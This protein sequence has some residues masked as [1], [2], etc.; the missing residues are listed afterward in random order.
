MKS[1]SK[2]EHGEE[3][4]NILAREWARKLNHYFVLWQESD[5]DHVLDYTVLPDFVHTS[6]FLDWGV[7][8]DPASPTWPRVNELHA[9]LPWGA[10]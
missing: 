4:G 2:E 6:E 1:F 5:E 7:T 3:A 8:V 9:W 10:A